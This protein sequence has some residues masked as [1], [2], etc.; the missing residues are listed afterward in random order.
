MKKTI[1][2]WLILK[3]LAII[4]LAT[5]LLIYTFY[6]YVPSI[7]HGLNEFLREL[8]SKNI[9]LII[10]VLPVIVFG[11][12]LSQIPLLKR[13]HFNLKKGFIISILLIYS[14]TLISP[15]GYIIDNRK[16]KVL[17]DNHLVKDYVLFEKK[18][19]R[20]YFKKSE[21]LRLCHEELN[22]YPGS[23]ADLDSFRLFVEKSDSN[24]KIKDEYVH[25]PDTF[26]LIKNYE[27][28]IDTI[29][30][31]DKTNQMN[32]Y[33][34]AIDYLSTQLIKKTGCRIFDKEKNEFVEYIFYRSVHDPLGN[35]DFYCYFPDGRAFIDKR[36]LYG[37]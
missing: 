35:K 1:S 25:L 12:I 15:L 9:L 5:N 3:I 7:N 14:Y 24:L 13:H 26:L 27:N 11:I 18:T 20:M 21:V 2:I 4:L 30:I 10:C 28:Q 23:F 36:L 33:I 17:T 19:V 22:E 16:I 37:L 29:L 32:W 34:E 31:T 8:F 6:W